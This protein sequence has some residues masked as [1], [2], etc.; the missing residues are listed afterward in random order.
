MH[1]GV[2]G[3]LDLHGQ[4]VQMKNSRLQGSLGGWQL[5]QKPN[6]FGYRPGL[7]QMIM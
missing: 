2:S 3:A 5:R 7:K 4:T 1:E 6:C